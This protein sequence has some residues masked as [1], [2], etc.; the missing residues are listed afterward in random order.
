MVCASIEHSDSMIVFPSKK[1][2]KKDSMKVVL[3]KGREREPWSA[4]ANLIA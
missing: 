2:K 3:L 1:K 4:V